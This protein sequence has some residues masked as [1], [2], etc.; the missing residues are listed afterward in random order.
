MLEW[1]I[2]YIRSNNMLYPKEDKEN[3]KLLYAVWIGLSS[4]LNKLLNKQTSLLMDC[5]EF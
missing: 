3:K 2:T 1:W 4:V 5:Y